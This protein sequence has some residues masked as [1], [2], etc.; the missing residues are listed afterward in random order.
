MSRTLKQLSKLDVGELKGVG[1]KKREALEALEI[2]TVLDLLTHYPRRY[3]DRTEQ[4]SI[5][6]LQI[7]EEAMVLATVKRVQSR[8]TRNG[9]SLVEID[10]FDGS[11]YLAIS[12][13]NQGWRAK[14][15]A[16][17]TEA[18]FFGKLTSYR[19]KRQM[20]SP[21]V[22]LI[23]DKTGRIVPVYPQSEKAALTTWELAKFVEEAL[24]RAGEFAD[25][26]PEDVRDR[27]DL[28]GRTWAM[29]QIHMPESIGRRR[30]RRASAWP[31]TNCC[32]ADGARRAQARRYEAEATG[33]RHV[34]DSE[35]VQAFHAALP[36]SLTGAQHK[37]IADI[38][39]FLA[40][41][42]RCTGCCRATSVRARPSSRSPR[43]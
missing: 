40:S 36:F 18:V 19:G 35:L 28:V 15:L 27:L 41:P 20:T 6:D 32:A 31:S 26:V 11:S 12:F 13:F 24:E 39:G 43:C 25:P 33:I 29:S 4:K 1:A 37:V 22:D 34:I 10:V 23:G 9:K 8:R 30:R 21:V 2:E 14:Q 16:V 7:D 17:G 42:R 38:N 3:I 5:K